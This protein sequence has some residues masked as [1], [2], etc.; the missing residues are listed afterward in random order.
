MEEYYS[1]LTDQLFSV[2]WT[3]VQM[4]QA[5]AQLFPVLGRR[6]FIEWRFSAPHLR[7]G[8]IPFMFTNHV[9]RD[10]LRERCNSKAPLF[11]GNDKLS[12]IVADIIPCYA[13]VCAKICQAG[14]TEW[15][16]WGPSET[17][18]IAPGD[19]FSTYCSR[20]SWPF[21]EKRFQ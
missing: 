8:I 4:E 7:R 9:T 3:T 21:I 11:R 13:P 12:M 16:L 19:I 14:V 18:V 20:R 15:V 17:L 1:R 10:Y 5:G 2:C 6:C